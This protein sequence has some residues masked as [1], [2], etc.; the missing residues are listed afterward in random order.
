M[1]DITYAIFFIVC[2]L[3]FGIMVGYKYGAAIH[4]NT[5]TQQECLS[6]CHDEF[7]KFAC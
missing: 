3:L 7:M 4:P 1:K 2:G 6:I 5:I